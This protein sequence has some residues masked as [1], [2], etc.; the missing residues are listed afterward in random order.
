VARRLEASDLERPY[1]VESDPFT[2]RRAKIT[3]QWEYFDIEDE[4]ER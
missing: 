3:A 1:Y 4:F 2:D